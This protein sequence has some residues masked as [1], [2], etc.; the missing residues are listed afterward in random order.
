MGAIA[1]W[2]AGIV[3][4]SRGGILTDSV[5]GIIGGFVGGFLFSAPGF[6]RTTGFNLWSMFVAFM[7]VVVLLGVIHWVNGRGRPHIFN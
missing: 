5:V 2:L 4:R 7:G 3:M 1:G 6:A